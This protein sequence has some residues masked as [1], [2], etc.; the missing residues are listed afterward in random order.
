MPIE[1]SGLLQADSDVLRYAMGCQIHIYQQNNGTWAYLEEVLD[2]PILIVIEV[3]FV[4]RQ[5]LIA[6]LH[7]NYRRHEPYTGEDKQV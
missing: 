7:C 4:L 5:C 3:S 2:L 6:L 1:L